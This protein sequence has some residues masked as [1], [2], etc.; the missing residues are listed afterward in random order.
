MKNSLAT[1]C[2]RCGH[3]MSSDMKAQL[4]QLPKKQQLEGE[5]AEVVVEVD[6]E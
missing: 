5:D 6:V 2:Q 4:E 1:Y 3:E